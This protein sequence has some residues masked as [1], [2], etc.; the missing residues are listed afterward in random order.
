MLLEHHE[1]IFNFYEHSVRFGVAE[2]I[3]GNISSSLLRLGKGLQEPPLLASQGSAHGGHRDAI[4]L[5]P[6]R[7]VES[8]TTKVSPSSIPNLP[9]V[10]TS[11]VQLDFVPKK[12]GH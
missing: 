11:E 10:Q 4:G 3:N 5:G 12:S 2:A 6:H 7:R 8:G 1:C 9:C